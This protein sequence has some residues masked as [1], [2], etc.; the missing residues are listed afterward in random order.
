[1]MKPNVFAQVLLI[2][3]VVG[4]LV[5][6]VLDKPLPGPLLMVLG[7]LCPSPVQVASLS[8]SPVAGGSGAAER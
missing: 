8:G 6:T 2:I 1:M 5:L 4:I 7:V 3:V